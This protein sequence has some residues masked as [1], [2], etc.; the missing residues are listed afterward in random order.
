MFWKIFAD[1]IIYFPV[2]LLIFECFKFIFDF[3]YKD[4]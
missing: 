2:A 4:E 3:P 1:M